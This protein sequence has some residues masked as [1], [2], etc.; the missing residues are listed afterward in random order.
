MS[1][2]AVSGLGPARIAPEIGVSA[3]TVSRVLVRQQRQ[4][5]QPVV[6][7]SILRYEKLAVAPWTKT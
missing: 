6:R 1:P 2:L 5:L 7:R 3:A 4:R